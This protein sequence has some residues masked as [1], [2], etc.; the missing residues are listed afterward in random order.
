[1]MNGSNPIARIAHY[2][3]ILTRFRG[4]PQMVF[5]LLLTA[6]TLTAHAR[7]VPDGWEARAENNGTTFAPAKMNPGEKFEIWVAGTLFDAPQGVSLP[8]LLQQ[9]RQQAGMQG[10]QCEPA[11]ASQ[12]NVVMQDCMDGNVALQY[13]LLPSATGAGKVQLVRVRAAGSDELLA[14]YGDG[15]QQVLRLAMQGQAQTMPR[16]DSQPQ[17]APRAQPQPQTQTRPEAARADSVPDGWQVRYEKGS[18]VIF[19]PVKMNRGEKLEILVFDAYYE[20][21]KGASAQAQLAEARERAEATEGNCQPPQVA[22]PGLVLA[23]QACKEGDAALQYILLRHDTRRAYLL[24]VRAAGNGVLERH[25]DGFQQVMQLARQQK[26][27]EVANEYI[28]RATRTA[29]G[30]GVRDGDIAAVYVTWEIAHLSHETV[31]RVEY[32]TR[33]LLKDGTGYLAA[34]FPPDE[35]NV[36]A[37]RQLEPARWFQWRKPLFGKGYEMRGQD[38][39]D[40]RRPMPEQSW[41]AQPA[42]SG[43]RLN[44]AYK[45]YQA[46]GNSNVGTFRTTQSTWYFNKDGTFSTSFLARTTSG[47]REVLNGHSVNTLTLADSEGTSTTAGVSQTPSGKM[48]DTPIFAGGSNRRSGDGA[49]RRGR[50]QFNGWVL[51][52]ERDDGSIGRYFVSFQSDKRDSINIGDSQYNIPKD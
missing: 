48:A 47:S 36:K 10:G 30:K 41:I 32:T 5:G 35:L 19:E 26:V 13:M 14:R 38:D 4:A 11:Q 17:T 7:D 8:N 40:W 45:E 39:K 15:F 20:V 25:K 23:T 12:N 33:L 28:K 52:V 6:F 24:R 9:I 27:W 31:R 16:G 18:S 43:E 3:R 50:Y 42:R 49:D 44:G 22:P 37:S 46:Y 1:M 51:E 2:W 21:L 29:P 34:S